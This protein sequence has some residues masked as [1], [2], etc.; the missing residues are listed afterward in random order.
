M[1]LTAFVKSESRKSLL[2]QRR[3]S[4]SDV[5]MDWSAFLASIG[6]GVD[7]DKLKRS[8]GDDEETDIK[9][10]L[11]LLME[12]DCSLDADQLRKLLMFEKGRRANRK[13]IDV[14]GAGVCKE[15]EGTT[16]DFSCGV[17]TA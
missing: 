7:G 13:M 8:V 4:A 17:D 12:E 2:E 6:I 1:D 5:E 15:E 10:V 11:D 14:K 9:D 3:E 16:T